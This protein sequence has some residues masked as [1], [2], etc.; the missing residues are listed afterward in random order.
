M[1]VRRSSLLR[2][3]VAAFA[4]AAVLVF[5]KGASA[6]E[7]FGTWR[8]TTGNVFEIHGSRH[9]DFKLTNRQTTGGT[10]L[11]RG[12]WV[13]G[14]EGTQFEYWD[15]QNRYTGTF[16]P[17]DAN[18]IR[19][20]SN[21]VV[22]W[23]QRDLN[24]PVVESR[25]SKIYG[26]WRSTSGNLFDITDAPGPG[27]EI[28]VMF[29]DGRRQRL[30]GSWIQGMRGSQFEYWDASQIRYE[31]TFNP[32]DPDRVRVTSNNVVS[33]W[34]RNGGAPAVV[35]AAPPPVAAAPAA[36]A[37]NCWQDGDPGCSRT[38]NG[39]HAMDRDAFNALQTSV[40][41]ASPHVFQMLDRF[42]T[43]I[44]NG[45]LTS[46]QL[47]VIVEMFKPHVFQM[48][49]AVKAAAPK[50]VDPQNGAGISEKFSPHVFQGNDAAKAIAAQR[51][52]P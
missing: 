15:G 27:F 50:L 47:G 5:S 1:T 44:G 48:L 8:S 32:T 41:S 38:K 17:R 13:R 37:Y 16:D 11:L 22:S 36:P 51:G 25:G 26:V 49:D 30:R 12:N 33:W 23:W 34:S 3:L 10:Q 21:S 14:L 45:Y 39:Q 35:A 19:V 2:L 46:R 42:K 31:G 28:Y 6:A 4:F 24:A 29:N 18:R 52:D 9:S 43:S 7:I 20:T 40:R